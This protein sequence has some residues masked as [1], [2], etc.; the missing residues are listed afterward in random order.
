MNE[1]WVTGLWRAQPRTVVVLERKDDDVR[2]MFLDSGV[3]STC[4][5]TAFARTYEPTRGRL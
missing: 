5:V 4:S 3:E 2:F 1:E